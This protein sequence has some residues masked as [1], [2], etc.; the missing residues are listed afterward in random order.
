[1]SQIDTLQDRHCRWIRAVVLADR[2]IGSS[3]E[4]IRVDSSDRSALANVVK[5]SQRLF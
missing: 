5:L 4:E 2:R 3:H 1:M